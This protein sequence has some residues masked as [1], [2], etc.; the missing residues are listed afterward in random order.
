MAKIN[1]KLTI[2]TLSKFESGVVVTTFLLALPML[3]NR[4]YWVSIISIAIIWGI[5]ALSYDLLVGQAGILSFGQTAPFGAAAFVSAYLMYLGFPFFIALLAGVFV[6]FIINFL[7]GLPVR[8]V[9]G[10]YYAILTLAF[11]EAIRISIENMSRYVGRSISFTVGHPPI[12]R[13]V[14][15]AHFMIFILVVL[16]IINLILV[17]RRIVGKTRFTLGDLI[18]T[19]IFIG[20]IIISIGAIYNY[21]S[22]YTLNYMRIT[23]L[24]MYFLSLLLLVL[25]YYFAKRVTYSPMG[26]VWRAMRENPVRAEVVGYNIYTY[27][28]FA[29]AISGAIA[30]VAGSLFSMT[31]I[32][33]SETAFS[34]NNTIMG[35][36]AIILGG[37]GTLI[38]PIIGMGIV[39][40]IIY[41]LSSTA[42]LSY[43]SMAIIGIIYIVVILVFPY[44]ML[45]TWYLKMT[46]IRRKAMRLLSR[47]LK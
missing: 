36:L 10:V 22:G 4:A 3:L 5:F 35:L 27:S 37:V 12:I 14:F 11:A 28:L 25:S 15:F 21:F 16:L 20:L 34:A 33:N 42:L 7:M 1:I 32:V 39:Q 6:G 13:S 31:T 30:G 9:K 26:S 47:K 38:G 2:N 40:L 45:G 29:L 41:F 19:L 44:G 17:Y 46:N 23:T 8:R 18:A 43:L 24:N